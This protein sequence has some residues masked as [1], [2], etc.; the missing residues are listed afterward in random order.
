[1]F[2][3]E[4]FP[5][6]NSIGISWSDFWNMNPRIIKLMIKGNREREKRDLE[7][8]NALAHLQGQYFVEA[9]MATVCNQ[10]SGKTGKKHEYPKKPYEINKNQ[11]LTEDELQK[12]REA[13]VAGL[14]V[15][16]SNFELEHPKK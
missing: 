10:L 14:M 12:Q 5:L 2:E 1:M 13:F 8:K 6:A 4:W 11:E 16:K 9:I 3:N 15:M 7:I